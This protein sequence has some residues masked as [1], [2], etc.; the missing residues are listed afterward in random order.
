MLPQQTKLGLAVDDRTSN[1]LYARCSGLTWSDLTV[2]ER[3]PNEPI[4]W[5]QQVRN[6][7]SLKGC[8]LFLGYVFTAGYY[9]DNQNGNLIQ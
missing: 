7:S 4:C 9:I 8:G 3:I 2:M 1:D 5:R 6:K